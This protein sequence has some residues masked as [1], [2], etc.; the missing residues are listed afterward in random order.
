VA[1]G[2]VR[3][4][5]GARRLAEKLR[6]LW[7]RALFLVSDDSSWISDTEIVVGGA[8]AATSG[9]TLSRRTHHPTGAGARR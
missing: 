8:L 7:Q 5:R 1:A 2:L 6:T 9:A 3:T 4:G